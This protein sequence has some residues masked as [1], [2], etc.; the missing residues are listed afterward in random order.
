MVLAALAFGIPLNQPFEYSTKGHS[1]VDDGTQRTAAYSEQYTFDARNRA[2]GLQNNLGT[3]TYAFV[4]QSSRSSTVTY[5]N[6][7]QVLYDYYAATGEFLLKQKIKNLSAGRRRSSRS[8]TTRTTSKTAASTR[9]RS[10]RAASRPRGRLATTA[11]GSSPTRAMTDPDGGAPFE[12][13]YYGYD[14]ASNRIQVGQARRLR[15]TMT[16][17]T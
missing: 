16:S 15:R 10:T 2:T 5:S 12:S 6:G 3:S 8:S 1:T 9:G 4:G 14:K 17:T 11:R 13:S 7:M